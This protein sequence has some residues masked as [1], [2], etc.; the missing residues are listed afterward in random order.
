MHGRARARARARA[1]GGGARGRG[2]APAPAACAVCVNLRT[3]VEPSP[4]AEERCRGSS[5]FGAA[6]RMPRPPRAA[7]AYYGVAVDR[8]LHR[9]APRRRPCPPARASASASGAQHGVGFFGCGCGGIIAPGGYCSAEAAATAVRGMGTHG[10]GLGVGCGDRSGG[11][12]GGGAGGVGAA[13]SSV[14]QPSPPSHQVHTL[15]QPQ[16]GPREVQAPPYYGGRR[17]LRAFVR[18]GVIGHPNRHRQLVRLRPRL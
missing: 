1:R 4:G 9:C 5:K 14:P 7:R 3:C 2:G 11:D 6:G 18:N 8:L 13:L 12:G 10:R 16:L 15:A 17:G